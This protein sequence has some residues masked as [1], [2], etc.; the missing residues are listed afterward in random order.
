MKEPEVKIVLVLFAV[1]IAAMAFK[2]YAYQE[3]RKS[4]VVGLALRVSKVPCNSEL[5]NGSICTAPD[6]KSVT[7]TIKI[8]P[9]MELDSSP[10]RYE[11]EARLAVF[12]TKENVRAVSLP[13]D[14]PRRAE[15][16]KNLIWPGNL[17]VVAAEEDESMDDFLKN[18]GDRFKKHNI[19]KSD[20]NG[21]T[22]YDDLECRRRDHERFSIGNPAPAGNPYG[23]SPGCS[24]RERIY[25][26]PNY[27]YAAAFCIRPMKD[28]GGKLV[29]LCRVISKAVPGATM[30]Y[31]VRGGN[32]IDGTWIEHDR[33]I[34]KY[35]AGL[36]LR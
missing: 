1:V 26:S 28:F 10:K 19:V 6:P 24:I 25:V 36:E 31:T 14:S 35:I 18:W 33:E 11:V 3:K 34:R 13:E 4:M 27:P 7:F 9:E 12:A 32:V 22:M 17:I 5:K 16:T 23:E 30:R 20:I 15:S 29:F 21:L 2:N 8:P